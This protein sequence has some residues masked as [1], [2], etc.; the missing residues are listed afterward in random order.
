MQARFRRVG[1]RGAPTAIDATGPGLEAKVR[2]AVAP[3][4]RL[5]IGVAGIGNL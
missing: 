2:F 1:H 3:G 5:A 4:G